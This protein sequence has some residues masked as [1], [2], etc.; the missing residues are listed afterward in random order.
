MS[1]VMH[2]F[3]SMSIL[4][5]LFL[6]QWPTRYLHLLNTSR[7]TLTHMLTLCWESLDVLRIQIILL[8]LLGWQR[9]WKPLLLAGCGS[10]TF[11]VLYV[12]LLSV[13]LRGQP[14]SAWRPYSVL[15]IC[16]DRVQAALQPIRNPPHQNIFDW[17]KIPAAVVSFQNKSGLHQL[18]KSSCKST[19]PTKIQLF[20]ILKTN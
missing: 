9:L 11:K 2:L 18:K 1:L 4:L 10:E 8:S 12:S 3:M 16:L 19:D 20:V 13:W 5:H 7:A 14:Y 6:N 15:P 17:S